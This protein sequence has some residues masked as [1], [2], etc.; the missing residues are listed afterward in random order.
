MRTHKIMQSKKVRIGLV[1]AIVALIAG[2]FFFKIL[3]QPTIT[4]YKDEQ[5]IIYACSQPIKAKQGSVPDLLGGRIETL[6]PADQNEAKRYCKATGI[7]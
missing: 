5:F 6:V 2:V 7:E 3:D 1:A 4:S